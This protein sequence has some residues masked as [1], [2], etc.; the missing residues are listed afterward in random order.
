MSVCGE[1]VVIF[2]LQY[3]SLQENKFYMTRM[4]I[5]CICFTEV[6][7]II[8]VSRQQHYITVYCLYDQIRKNEVRGACSMYG[9]EQVHIGFWWGNLMEGDPLGIRMGAWSGSGQVLAAGCCER[10]NEHSGSAKG[11][12]FLDYL[13]NKNICCMEL[14]GYYCFTLQISKAMWIHKHNDTTK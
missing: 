2:L 8:C 7:K 9:G 14:C 6:S 4:K 1:A 5:T 12:G 11:R 10:H 13:L 3:C